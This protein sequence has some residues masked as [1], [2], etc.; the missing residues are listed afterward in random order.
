MKRFGTM[1][2]VVVAF[3]GAAAQEPAPTA[4]ESAAIV[5]VTGDRQIAITGMLGTV[6]L[7]LGKPGELRFLSRKPGGKVSPKTGKPAPTEELP[8]ALYDAGTSLVLKPAP[9]EPPGTV[10]DLQMSIPP[11]LFVRLEMDRGGKV[12]LS[13]LRGGI[14]IEGKQIVLDAR[15]LQSD[16][17]VI[18]EGATIVGGSLGGN[19]RLR[20][21]EIQATLQGTTG[22]VGADLVGG[23]LK[24]LGAASIDVASEG[25]A[26]ELAQVKERATVKASGGTVRITGLAGGGEFQITGASLAMEKSK[27]DITVSSDADVTYKEMEADLHFD[28]YGGSVRGEGNKGLVEARTRNA[29]VEL[30]KN[31]GPARVQGDGLVVKLSDIGGE[32]I[33]YATTSEVTIDNVGG[34]LTVESDRGDV[35][36]SR[37]N[38]EVEL[39]TEGGGVVKLTD[40]TGAVKVNAQSQSVEVSWSSIPQADS[41]IRN[42]EGTVSVRFP[43]TGT[44]C[45]VEAQSD[46]GRIETDLPRVRVSDDGS[47]AEGQFGNAQRPVVNVRAG[48]DIQLLGGGA[49][50]GSPQP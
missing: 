18:A 7:Q 37:I 2:A 39:T 10:R 22:S 47:R 24:V 20:G 5:P 41:D 49:T 9:G 23:S 14:E 19:V 40:L 25:T 38:G 31:E 8:V 28:I 1:L 32:T 34:K 26:V 36:I 30:A 21:R 13:G 27:G 15:G 3:A 43:A 17:E 35:T 46:D 16:L 44:G 50:D 45:R 12:V 6:S 33:V 11:E 4:V 29:T 42:G 48:G